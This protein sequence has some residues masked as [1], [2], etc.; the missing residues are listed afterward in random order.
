MGEEGGRSEVELCMGGWYGSES[1]GDVRVWAWLKAHGVC[2]SFANVPK[3][4]E[5]ATNPN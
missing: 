4:T 3:K 5:N 1:L 2:E